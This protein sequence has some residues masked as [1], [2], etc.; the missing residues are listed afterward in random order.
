M[1]ANNQEHLKPKSEKAK[2]AIDQMVKL[3]QKDTGAENAKAYLLAQKLWVEV[4]ATAIDDEL[5][6]WFA[7]VYSDNDKLDS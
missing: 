7:V 4:V 1:S 6:R 5:N 2:L 3:I